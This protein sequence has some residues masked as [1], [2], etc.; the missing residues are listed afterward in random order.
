MLL[1]I[2][3]MK[4]CA[5]MTNIE[6]TS[7]LIWRYIVGILG[8]R[9][10][11]IWLA[12]YPRAGNT[13]VRFLLCN[14][15]SLCE[16]DGRHVDFHLLDATMPA[17]G[18]SNLF[19]PWNFQ[20]IPRFIKTHQ[21]YRRFLF[22]LPEQALYILRD[23][24]DVMI[25]YYHFLRN[26]KMR[27]FEGTFREFIHHP[28][29]GLQACVTHYLTWQPHVDY[30]VRYEALQE[31][32]VSEFQAVLSA[33]QI[34]IPDHYVKEAVERSAFDK[35]RRVQEKTGLSGPK[36]FDQGFQFAREGRVKQWHSYFTDEDLAFYHQICDEHGVRL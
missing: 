30:V 20:T 32:T 12:S 17:L 24:R 21:P 35:I 7:K 11:D 14:L 16:L 19:E 8:L 1:E 6:R 3:C 23:P 9:S 15:I 29:Y 22:R 34:S 27:R 36:R 31:D 13:W 2:P 33:F 10:D 18:Y 4:V 5:L 28:D 26:H 25:S